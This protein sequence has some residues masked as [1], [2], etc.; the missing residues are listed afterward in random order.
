VPGACAVRRGG[1]MEPALPP[2]GFERP[3][4]AAG[5]VERVQRRHVLVGE[6]EVEDLRVLRDSLTVGRLRD[7]DELALHAPAQQDLGGRSS[8]ALG[9]LSDTLVREVP[10][11]AEWAARGTPLSRRARP[12]LS[13]LP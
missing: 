9:D 5:L 8:Y 3:F 1:A 11:G 6:R 4:G 7:D 13:S 12:T 2:G 10:A